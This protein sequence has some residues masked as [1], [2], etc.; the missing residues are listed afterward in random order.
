MNTP[1][2]VAT[3]YSTSDRLNARIQLHQRFGVEPKPWTR[4]LFDQFELPAN[5]QLLEV[6]CGTGKLWQE[7]LDQLRDSWSITLTD[8]SPGMLA[9]TR[10]ILGDQV[11]RFAIEQMD[12]QTLAFHDAAFDA[13]IAN[14]M[15]YHVP[16]L[17]QGLSEIQRVLKPDGK[18]FAATNGAQHLLELHELVHEF[19]ANFAVKPW[20]LGFSLENGAEWLAPYFRQVTLVR[21]PSSLRVTEADPIVDYVR[22]MDMVTPAHQ[23]EFRAFVQATLRKNDGVIVIQREAGLFRANK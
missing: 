16:D 1:E 15:L 23:D 2:A 8:Q 10:E 22:S 13:V 21:F 17:N 5:A 12:V 7:N 14:H 18:L 3:Q 11:A 9:Q 20:R 6:G 19:D 4:W